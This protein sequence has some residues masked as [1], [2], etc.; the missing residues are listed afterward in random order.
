MWVNGDSTL[1]QTPTGKNILIDTGE[2][3][4]TIVEYL[5]D[6]KIKTL[7]FLIISHFDSDHSGRA[8]EIIETLEVKNI[9]ISKQA[10]ISEQFKNTIKAAKEN[11]VNIIIVK[12]GDTVKVCKEIYFQI[13]WPKTEETITENALNNNSIVAKFIYRDFSILFTGDIEETAEK[14][15]LEEYKKSNI[16]KS[17]TLKI[18]HHGSNTSSIEEFIKKVKPQLS[19]I[20]VGKNNK[21]GHPNEDIVE[22]L[23]SYGSTVYRTDLHGEITI[24]VTKKGIIKT[25]TYIR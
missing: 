19:V 9:I 17:T 1:I 7:D 22:R 15:I 20:G 5:L 16:L 3:E 25:S 8:V 4:Q 24:E 11:N 6:R 2:A 10:E 13:L 21:F 18:A 12:A 23:K 14:A